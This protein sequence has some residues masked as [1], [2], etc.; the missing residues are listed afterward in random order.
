MLAQHLL[1]LYV[2]KCGATMLEQSHFPLDQGLTTYTS[3]FVWIKS[4]EVFSNPSPARQPAILPPT[5]E[6]LPPILTLVKKIKRT[7]TQIATN[8]KDLESIPTIH[9]FVTLIG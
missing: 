3:L 6:H 1:A 4:K 5:M 8:N 2:N 9:A 7:V